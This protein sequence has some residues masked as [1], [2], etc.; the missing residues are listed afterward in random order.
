ML[1]PSCLPSLVAL[2]L[3]GCKTEPAAVLSEPGDLPVAFAPSGDEFLVVVLP[4]TQIY[5]MN[6]PSTFDSQLS[7]IAERADEYNIVFVSHVGDIVHNASE[8][9]EWDAALAAYSLLDAIDL[10]HGFS[11]GGHDTSSHGYDHPIDSSCSPFDTTDCGAEDF[12]RNF[13]PQHFEGRSW[14]GGASPSGRSSYQRVEAGGLPLLFLHLLQD[15]P[16]AEV[17]WAKGVLEAHP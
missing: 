5:A 7:W 15:T 10:P 3:L 16:Q 1:R 12:L 17:D 11:V 13:G 14:F 2:V 9:V 6:H 8:Q 4:D